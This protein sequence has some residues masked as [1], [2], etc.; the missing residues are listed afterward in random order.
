MHRILQKGLAVLAMLQIFLGGLLVSAPASAAY[1]PL[2]ISG[3]PTPTASVGS[4]YSFTP[5]LSGG[6]GYN[7]VC[8]WLGSDLG[9]FKV[10][11]ATCAITGTPTTLTSLSG[12]LNIR[13]SSGESSL[14][15]SVTVGP[16]AGLAVSGT[17]PD[18]VVGQ[19]YSFT[20][21]ITGGLG[22]RMCR[23]TGRV[24]TGLNLDPWT[25]TLSGT[26]QITTRTM[27]RLTIYVADK[28]GE[29]ALPQA[30]IT[31]A[32]AS[33]GGGGTPVTTAFA[34]FPK[35]Q[36][37]RN[38]GQRAIVAM[39]GDSLFAGWGAGSTTGGAAGVQAGQTPN[40]NRSNYSTPAYIAAQ[41]KAAGIP[42]RSDAIF[43][44]GGV[45]ASV[46]S[47]FNDANPVFQIG[48]GGAISSQPETMGGP[49]IRTDTGGTTVG[50]LNPQE[51]TDKVDIYFITGVANQIL[52]ATDSDGQIGTYDVGSSSGGGIRK[53]TISRATPSTKPIT[54]T[55]GAA[56]AGCYFLGIIPYNSQA[57]MVEIWNWGRGGWKVSDAMVT[58]NAWSAGSM[59]PIYNPDAVVV[60]LGANDA[61][62]AISASTY[63]TNLQSLITLLSP[64][65][66]DIRLVKQHGSSTG[67]ETGYDAPAGYRTAIDTLTTSNALRAAFN[68]HDGIIATP[69]DYFDNIHLIRSGYSKEGA[70]VSADM[71]VAN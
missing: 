6:T 64:T 51:L 62:A 67:G 61:N 45:Q 58:T 66:R 70:L 10:D 57:P 15:V 68:F 54:I 50:T 14:P 33:S 3:T 11:P 59:V 32:Q 8:Y 53:I 69:A 34:N 31:V 38:A 44:S 46:V 21:T 60:S 36:A 52:T 20:P 5:S 42:A 12:T 1:T 37:K 9:Q 65:T 19:Y 26:P 71:Q 2:T 25:C 40:N 16:A 7:R 41:L 13:D 47:Y 35:V 22:Q 18:A 56:V 49:M 17:P 55:Q 30:L 63:Q 29:V 43:G 39:L 28:T 4:A 24:P 48:S 27:N 23:T